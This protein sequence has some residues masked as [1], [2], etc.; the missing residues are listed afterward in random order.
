M[1]NLSTNIILLFLSLCFI[2]FSIIGYGALFAKI[3][4]FEKKNN[5]NISYYGI[6]G[7]V[8]LVFFSYFSNLFYNHN[9]IFNLILHLVGICFYI[10]FFKFEKK[11]KDNKNYNFFYNNLFF[12]Y[13]DIKKS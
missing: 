12:I 3:F 4:I 7:L 13:F 1:I 6:F 10:F 9:E 5:F 11:N 8:F 2:T